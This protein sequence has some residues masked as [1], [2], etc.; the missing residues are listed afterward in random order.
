MVWK[1]LYYFPN[2]LNIVVLPQDLVSMKFTDFLNTG[3]QT[4]FLWNRKKSHFSIIFLWL[5]QIKIFN[6]KNYID[7]KKTLHR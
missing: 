5:I 7:N 2:I 4:K 1:E 3:K 6:N